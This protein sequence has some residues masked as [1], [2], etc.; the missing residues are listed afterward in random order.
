MTATTSVGT[1]FHQLRAQVQTDLLARLPDHIERLRWSRQQIEASQRKGLRE[2]LAHALENSPFHRR[3]LGDFDPSRFDLPDLTGLPVMTK[4]EMMESLDD[5]FTDRRLNRGLVDQALAA[6]ATEPVPILGQYTALASGGVSGQRGVFVSDPEA[7]VAYLSSTL[8]SLMAR[9]GPTGSLRPEGL[10]IALVAA[11]TAVHATR[12][13]LA[14]TEGG[15]SPFR[16]IPVPVTLPLPE[17]VEQ[18]NALQPPLL[19]GYASVLARLAAEQRAGRL[20]I[21]PMSVTTTSEMLFPEH[22]SAIAE[23]FGAPIVDIFGSSEGLVGTTAPD[24]DV[25]VF[26]SD[27]CIVELVDAENRPV[28]PGA[29][30]AKV[31]LTNLCNR[32]QPLIRYELTDSFVRQPDAADHGHLRSKVR[33]RAD[34]VLHYQGIDIHPHVV[35]SVMV[36]SPEILDYRVRQTPRGIDV[37]ALAVDPINGD[38]LAEDLVQALAAAG[39]RDPAVS[40]RIVDHL[41]RIPDTGKLRRFVPLTPVT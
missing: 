33:G 39:L 18:L 27:L 22:R 40:V 17:I 23:A 5:V 3:R 9:V 35:R 29:P 14:W 32:T 34:E 28:S 37:E 36:Q 1:D 30:S 2:L 25:L 31:L 16:A 26:N 7:M 8:R 24:D 19:Y 11:T 15:A 21:A 6:T 38:R 41:E 4:A 12:S 20:R 10:T 13:V